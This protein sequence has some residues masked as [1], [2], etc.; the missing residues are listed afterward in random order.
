MA[1]NATED[2]FG[3]AADGALSAV[4]AARQTH[5]RAWE[6]GGDVPPTGGTPT[7]WEQTP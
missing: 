7:N 6:D 3:T 4:S 2:R 1:A 5:L